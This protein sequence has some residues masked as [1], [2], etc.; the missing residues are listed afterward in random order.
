MTVQTYS[1]NIMMG[2]SE[3]TKK[4]YLH[5]TPLSVH[6]NK[7]GSSTG[8]QQTGSRYQSPLPDSQEC[9][10]WCQLRILLILW[11]RAQFRLRTEGEERSLA[12]LPWLR[13]WVEVVVQCY[14]NPY[15]TC[16]ISPAYV[17]QP[18]SGSNP[19]RMR[20]TAQNQGCRRYEYFQ[21]KTIVTTRPPTNK[22]ASFRL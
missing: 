15:S 4:V 5:A 8:N 19:L 3:T 17:I 14:F 9:L 2:I 11:Y 18:E 7:R 21:R 22:K 16:T 13:R 20:N 1:I 12:R 10:R 6:R